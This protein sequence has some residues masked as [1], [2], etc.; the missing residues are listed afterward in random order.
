MLA[1]G[2]KYSYLTL[3]ILFNIN[4]LL[5]HSLNGF[6]YYYL[7]VID[8]QLLSTNYDK[9]GLS[10]CLPQERFEEYGW[11]NHIGARAWYDQSIDRIR[12]LCLF[13]PLRAK[14]EC[15]RS[16]DHLS[17]WIMDCLAT[18]IPSLSITGYRLQVAS[19]ENLTLP[20]L[21]HFTAPSDRTI[22]IMHFINRITWVSHRPFLVSSLLTAHSHFWPCA[23]AKFSKQL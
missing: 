22:V 10:T 8:P 9:I 3:I 18:K 15:C 14:A 5:A 12:P 17:C 20:L 16:H 6:K 7:S 23:S 13:S 2:F 19:L 11:D 4:H 21:A 1:H